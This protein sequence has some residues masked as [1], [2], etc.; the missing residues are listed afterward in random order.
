MAIQLDLV[1]GQHRVQ[2]PATLRLGQVILRA[3]RRASDS[4]GDGPLVF[5]VSGGTDSLA[6]LLAAA[7]VRRSLGHEVVVAH[8]SHGFRKNAE[9]REAALVRRVTRLLQLS[10]EHEQADIQGSEAFARDARYAFFGRVVAARG[11]AAL[12]TAHTQNDQAET[13][14]LRLSRG[15]GLRGAGA[16]RE[17]SKRIVSQGGG[18]PVT[19]LRPML[20]ATRGDTEEV[21]AEWKWTPASDGTNRSLRYAR[22]RVRR[23][24]LPQLAQINP[25]VVS[26]LAAFAATAQEDDDLLA[27]LA[28][29]A[30]VGVE[31]REPARSAWPVHALRELAPPLLARVLRS[32][33]ARLHQEGAT[34]SRVQIESIEQSLKRGSGAVDLGGGAIFSVEHDL[35]SLSMIDVDAGAF[36]SVP[37]RIPG[38]TIVGSW[39]ITTSVQ[40]VGVMGNSV[41]K[42]TLDLDAL[43]NDLSVRC[44][45]KGDRFHPLG[46]NQEVRLQDV[47][48]NA[49]VPRSQRSS[50][51]L[52]IAG[53][54]IAW[55]AG[56]RLAD[57]AKVTNSTSRSLLIEARRAS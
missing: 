56:L 52:L 3:V 35:A 46:M 40:S 38:E 9:R 2:N 17:L 42:A 49:K 41:W 44:R 14:L 36:E 18:E 15:T 32:A 45:V 51:P 28:A 47:L 13:L 5:A 43:G 22:N 23:R 31:Q 1:P 48:V 27:R 50:I 19:L 34:L 21:C 11:A 54:R 39:T 53:S 57:W 33:W 55:V 26:S 12:S 16:I 30:I 24:V 4:L 8:F 29:A 10:L 6:M 25:S 20:N 7:T 37:V